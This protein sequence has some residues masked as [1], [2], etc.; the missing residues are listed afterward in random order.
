[1]AGMQT[2]RTWGDELTLRAAADA[3]GC[4]VH[5]ITSTT[6]NWHLVYQPEKP[7]EPPKSLFLTYVSP[8]HYNTISRQ[9]PRQRSAGA[10]ASAGPTGNGK[11]AAAPPAANGEA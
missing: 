6:E 1:M 10:L 3:F 8:V 9:A 5:V 4:V 2:D 7:R 11:S